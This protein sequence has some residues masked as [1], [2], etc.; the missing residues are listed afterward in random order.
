MWA[1]WSVHVLNM[2]G[3]LIFSFSKYASNSQLFFFIWNLN[4]NAFTIIIG[5]TNY[6]HVNM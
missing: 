4:R 1:I 6:Q 5:L 3:Y 2:S